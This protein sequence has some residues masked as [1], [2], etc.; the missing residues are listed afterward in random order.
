MIGIYLGWHSGLVVMTV[1]A[2]FDSPV[3]LHVHPVGLHVFPPLVSS[4]IDAVRLIE[5]N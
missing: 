4:Q 2:R 5:D 1:T 3:S